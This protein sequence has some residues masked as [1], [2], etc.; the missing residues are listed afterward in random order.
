MKVKAAMSAHSVVEAIPVF[1]FPLKSTSLIKPKES[2]LYTLKKTIS[3]TFSV[4]KYF[5]RFW[6]IKITGS[7]IQNPPSKKK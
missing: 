3:V 1:D 4:N 7:R 2:I 6:G 5:N